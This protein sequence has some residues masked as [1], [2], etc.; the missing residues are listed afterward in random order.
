MLVPAKARVRSFRVQER[1]GLIWATLEEPRWPL[2]EVPELETGEWATVAAGPY[3]W[4]CDAGI[5]AE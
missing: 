5:S 4:R 1:Y 2:P 3:R